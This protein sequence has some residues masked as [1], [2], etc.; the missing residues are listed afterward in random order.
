LA[1]WGRVQGE[2][3]IRDCGGLETLQQIASAVDAIEE[4][5]ALVKAEGWM[6]TTKSTR[7]VH[8]AVREITGLRAF[9]VRSLV[10]LGINVEPTKPAAG[11]P[12]RPTSWLGPEA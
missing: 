12:T 7:K 8:P 9:V 3:A 11:R 4:L 1:F 10:T 5:T 2:Y 6:V